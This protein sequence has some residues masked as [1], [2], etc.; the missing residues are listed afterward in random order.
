MLFTSWT[1]YFLQ[2]C[3]DGPA[4]Y[5]EMMPSKTSSPNQDTE[6]SS[7]DAHLQVD[8]R[9]SNTHMDKHTTLPRHSDH[10]HTDSVMYVTLDHRLLPH[11]QSLPRHSTHTLD[12]SDNTTNRTNISSSRDSNTGTWG[13]SRYNNG[14]KPYGDDCTTPL[15]GSWPSPTSGGSPTSRE[16]NIIGKDME[17]SQLLLPGQRESSVWSVLV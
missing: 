15:V 16:D 6:T 14:T 12:S 9:F 10:L 17:A 3:A 1:L 4:Q 5:T 2:A 13:G 8:N 7:L 11:T